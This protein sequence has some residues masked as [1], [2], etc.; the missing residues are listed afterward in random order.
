MDEV[1][2]FD[3]GK[4][5]KIPRLGSGAVRVPASL[6]RTGVFS[7]TM[8]DGSTRREWRP[9][10][11]VFH[12]DS[13][14][15]AKGVPVTIGHP[16]EGF[17]SPSN[18]GRLRHGFVTDQVTP[19]GTHLDGTLQLDTDEI[20]RG[21]NKGDLCEIS[22]GYKCKIDNTPGTTPDGVPYDAVQRL[23]RY[24]HSGVGPEK[25]GRMGRTASLH[26][27]AE[28]EVID[29]G[30]RL[31]AKGDVVLDSPDQEKEQTMVKIKIDGR[32]FV[33]GSP[34]HISYLQSK[35][36][37]AEKRADS[38]SKRADSAEGKLSQI[39]KELE[40]ANDPA[41]LDSLVSERT[42]VVE[43]ARKVIGESF[44]ADGKSNVMIMRECL[45]DGIKED[46]SDAHVIGAFS[47][48]S[49]KI[50]DP[51]T[52]GTWDR[53]RKADNSD[54]VKKAKEEREDSRSESDKARQDMIDGHQAA[55]KKPL[56]MSK[57]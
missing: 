3:F 57:G 47:Y 25:W 26:L 50:N 37:S 49:S 36:D 13:I 7:Y 5:G 23:I 42:G 51:Q 16:R 30:F 18:V 12:E 4:L 9:P 10:E 22:M 6:T 41:R 2:R 20:Q 35:I 43:V 44:R 40:A 33:E 34:E 31:D 15:S 38:E 19:N 27:D 21:V 11:E 8:P 24:N 52:G 55:W 39:T 1:L 29:T 48:M 14:N 28:S 17:V 53:A 46:A 32:E 56:A 54:A 45:G